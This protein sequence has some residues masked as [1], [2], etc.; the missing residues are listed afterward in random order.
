MRKLFE[1]GLRD[2][3][4]EIVAVE[5]EG[6]PTAAR[7]QR[8]A[9]FARPK[10]R[11]TPAVE[12]GGTVW[13]SRHDR[14][15][16]FGLRKFAR[17]PTTVTIEP[18][19]NDLSMA[20][21]RGNRP[22]PGFS[23]PRVLDCRVFQF[24]AGLAC[25]LTCDD[26]GHFLREEVPLPL[27]EEHLLRG[28][29]LLRACHPPAMLAQRLAEPLERPLPELRDLHRVKLTVGGT[30]PFGLWIKLKEDQIDLGTDG[31]SM[32]AEMI[33]SSVPLHSVVRLEV[34]RAEVKAKGEPLP[35]LFQLYAR[36][37]V[38]RRLGAWLARKQAAA[39]PL[40]YRSAGR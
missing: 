14:V 5:P 40:A 3:H 35:P 32:A 28:Q 9:L 30:L 12:A 25:V 1:A 24:K 19:A 34:E 7:L 36:S 37:L 21:T 17:R 11:Y 15:H 20:P 4:V 33:L 23:A 2:Q 27:L 16:K 26:Q 22:D 38:L 10:P 6:A 31:W 8:V 29:E 13:V 39:M 18:E